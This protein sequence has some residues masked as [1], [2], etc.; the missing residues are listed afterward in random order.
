[1]SVERP[2]ATT[3][4]YTFWFLPPTHQQWADISYAPKNAAIV[5]VVSECES[6]WCF[7]SRRWAHT[8]KHALCMLILR[9]DN[10]INLMRDMHMN[11]IYYVEWMF[12]VYV[13][14]RFL[15]TYL[16]WMMVWV[17]VIITWLWN[18]TCAR[19]RKT[20]SP[21]SASHRFG[22]SALRWM[23]VRS[24]TLLASGC[25]TELQPQPDCSRIQTIV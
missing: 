7:W 25:F 20:R 3:L 12:L 2:L 22:W 11:D 10:L 6:L 16:M 17:M 1:M 15:L 23:Q 24:I 9:S 21:E 13:R 18:V 4:Y 14:W 8:R 19:N 5:V